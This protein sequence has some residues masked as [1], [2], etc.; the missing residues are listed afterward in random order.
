[1][2]PVATKFDSSNGTPAVVPSTV[3]Q[4]G[5]LNG[6]QAK[7]E[8]IT[9]N[10]RPDIFIGAMNDDHLLE[11][12]ESEVIEYSSLTAGILPDFHNGSPIAVSGQLAEGETKSFI[13]LGGAS[14]RTVWCDTLCGCTIVS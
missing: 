5:S 13:I 1:M 3:N 9:G 2:S 6:W 8:D 12:K 11:N 4:A 7:S 14:G 10:G